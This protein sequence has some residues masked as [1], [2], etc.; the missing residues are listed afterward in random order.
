[1]A[2]D[3]AGNSYTFTIELSP[4]W[5]SN[6]VMP[7]GRKVKLKSSIA[8]SFEG[9]SSW[10]VETADTKDATVYKGGMKFYVKADKEYTFSKQ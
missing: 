10:M 5:M 9:G 8:Y 6:N 3:K 2:T 1:M 7:V 4:Q